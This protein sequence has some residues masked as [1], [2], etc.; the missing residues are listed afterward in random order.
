MLK[1]SNFPNFSEAIFPSNE[2]R[3]YAMHDVLASQLLLVVEQQTLL[4]I[5]PPDD[6]SPFRIRKG[7]AA[8]STAARRSSGKAQA[9]N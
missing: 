4:A 9:G 5:T 2:K 6:S 3:V 1:L 7:A 8:Y